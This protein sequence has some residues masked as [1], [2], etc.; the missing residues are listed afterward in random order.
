MQQFTN[1]ARLA[2]D[3][4]FRKESAVFFCVLHRFPIRLQVDD[5]THFRYDEESKIPDRSVR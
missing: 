2:S 4:R 1:I 5:S 3:S